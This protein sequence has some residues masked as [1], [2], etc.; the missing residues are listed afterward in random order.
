LPVKIV[1]IR[2]LSVLPRAAAA[3]SI[4]EEMTMSCPVNPFLR[5]IDS[6]RRALSVNEFCQEHDVSKTFVYKEFN[7]GRLN[8]VKIR[9]RRL[10]PAEAVEEWLHGP[11]AA[12]DPD[13][14]KRLQQHY[15]R[16]EPGHS[17]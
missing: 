14:V 1:T 5:G 15:D 3:G 17:F 9:G 6:S 7:A 10:I 8:S 13:E 4:D 16:W 11:D 12:Q 2:I